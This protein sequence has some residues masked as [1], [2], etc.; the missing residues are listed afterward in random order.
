M[1]IWCLARVHLAPVLTSPSDVAPSLGEDGVICFSQVGFSLAVHF[2]HQD[3][4]LQKTPQTHP[5]PVYRF[6][7]PSSSKATHPISTMQEHLHVEPPP[8]PLAAGFVSAPLCHLPPK[9]FLEASCSPPAE[10]TDAEPFSPR[11]VPVAPMVA[12]KPWGFTS[13]PL[14][15]GTTYVTMDVSTT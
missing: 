1:L 2:R 13:A 15:L 8:P 9:P 14:H 6:C 12:R 10:A 3:L 5:V 4:C 7:R 11:L